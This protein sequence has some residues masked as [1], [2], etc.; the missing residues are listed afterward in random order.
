MR[1]DI[2]KAALFIFL[3]KTCFNGLYR[4]NRKGEFNV[5][6]G[7]LRSPKICDK[8]TL[9]AASE[10]LQHVTILNGDYSDTL[11]HASDKTFYY[12]DPPYKPVSNTSCFNSYTQKVFDDAE[13]ERL[14]NFCPALSKAGS[15]WMLSNS[16]NGYIQN[17][18][19][20]IANNYAITAKRSINSNGGKRGQILELLLTKKVGKHYP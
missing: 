10:I 14:R 19:T 9:I 5:S 13:Q 3:N 18:Y 2:N 20:R 1:Y 17:L 16:N 15:A 4:V 12:I 6:F 7:N 11:K 8:D